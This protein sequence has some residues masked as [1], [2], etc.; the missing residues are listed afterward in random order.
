MGDKNLGLFAGISGIIIGTIT[1]LLIFG[2]IIAGTLLG[3]NTLGTEKSILLFG[4][5]PLILSV[6]GLI[7]SLI[8]KYPIVSLIFLSISGL[9]L[10]YASIPL[11]TGLYILPGILFIL[12][13]KKLIKNQK[14]ESIQKISKK[15][16]L[17]SILILLVL[18][19]FF[20]YQSYNL[21]KNESINPE[22][23]YI[24]GESLLNFSVELIL[25]GILPII[26]GLIALASILKKKNWGIWILWFSIFLNFRSSPILVI[27]LCI[28]ILFCTKTF[29]EKRVNKF[30]SP[31]YENKLELSSKKNRKELFKISTEKVLIIIGI[32]LEVLFSIIFLWEILNK[33]PVYMASLLAIQSNSNFFV[34]M[35]ISSLLPVILATIGFILVS[36]NPKYSALFLISASIFTISSFNFLYIP[37]FVL[38]IIAERRIWKKNNLGTTRKWKW[39]LVTVLIAFAFVSV[40]IS[41]SQKTIKIDPCNNVSYFE[42]SDCFYDAALKFNNSLFCFKTDSEE[43]CF[44]ELAIITHNDSLCLNII[45]QVYKDLCYKHVAEDNYN[46]NNCEK[47]MGGELKDECFMNVARDTNN[48]ELCNRITKQNT[49]EWCLEVI[50]RILGDPKICETMTIQKQI[51]PCFYSVAKVKK[52]KIFCEKINSTGWK[53]ECVSLP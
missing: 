35:F 3:G 26:I 18:L 17:L 15:I 31:F 51:D 11:I 32:I 20:G 19:I 45:S 21:I 39:I 37:S 9:F 44:K 41:F 33:N 27:I 22:I 43:S 28:N 48:T 2:F 13:A 53:K 24:Y 36:K 12:A 47:I 40:E 8:K 23:T 50:N 7:G 38:F 46:P 14:M 29:D 42:K 1:T 5:I 10:I 16:V 4:I 52:D 34:L 6:L 49:K 30:K 25:Y